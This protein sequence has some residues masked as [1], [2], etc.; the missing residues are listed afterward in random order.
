MTRRIGGG[1]VGIIL[2]FAPT[3]RTIFGQTPPVWSAEVP[4]ADCW[5]E[6]EVELSAKEM[7]AQLVSA[8][9]ISAP[10]L[11]RAMR[12][13]GAVLSFIVETDLDGS[14]VCVRA[15]SGHPILIGAALESIRNWRFRTQKASMP[16][17]AICGLLV[18]EI[19]L[20]NS[21]LKARILSG[22]PE[23]SSNIRTRAP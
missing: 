12:I 8:R 13:T 15:R 18:I 20:S 22:D 14:V 6:G 3:G 7:K 2:A 19:S 5:H 17:Q 21:K 16:R 4:A 23:S 10:L 11:Y 9:P 1:L